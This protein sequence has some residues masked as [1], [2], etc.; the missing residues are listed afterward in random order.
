MAQHDGMTSEEL[1]AYPPE[2]L[3]QLYDAG[4]I[5]G[6]QARLALK[7]KRT[8]DR[9]NTA[10]PKGRY[11][12]RTYV[13]ANPLEF[14]AKGIRDYKDKK[15]I[16]EIEGQQ[17]VLAQQQADARA[18]YFKGGQA[19]NRGGM[20]QGNDVTTFG[21]PEAAPMGAGQ[22]IPSDLP[23]QV[24]PQQAQGPLPQ[25]PPLNPQG[26]PPNNPPSGGAPPL[27]PQQMQM[28]QQ[29]LQ[30]Q[31]GGGMNIQQ[32]LAGALRR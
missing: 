4:Q 10:G 11:T 7:L 8:K 25:P 30:S 1:A 27:D 6:K 12:G 15:S 23:P 32:Q 9:R 5:D 20:Y 21:M 31:Q 22:A 24:A 13:A 19:A 18:E 28:M 16:G 26:L 17:D 2:V 29:W 3:K 14:L